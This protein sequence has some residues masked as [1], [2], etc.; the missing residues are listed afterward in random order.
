MSGE[1]IAIITVGVAL[2]GLI[3]TSFRSL[4]SEMR[5]DT[6]ALREEMRS[7]IGGLREENRSQTGNLQEEMRSQTGNLQEEVAGVRSD[8]AT[9]RERMAHLEG[10][11]EGL[12]EA[13]TRRAA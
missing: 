3:L 10:L 6:A 2:A 9:L 12:R 8:I 7:Q 4:R 11:L 13:I 1:I 5:S